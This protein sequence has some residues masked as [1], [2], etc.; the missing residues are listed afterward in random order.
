MKDFENRFIKCS[1]A[2][3]FFYFLVFLEGEITWFPDFLENTLDNL[4][5]NPLM[6]IIHFFMG[7]FLPFFTFSGAIYLIGTYKKTGEV[8][9]KMLLLNLL[10]AALSFFMLN[11]ILSL[12]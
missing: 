8:N 10:I 4:F 7:F 2:I 1:I 3:L 12:H 6:V 9:Q 5:R 11:Q